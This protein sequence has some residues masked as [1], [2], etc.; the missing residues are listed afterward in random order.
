MVLKF[1]TDSSDRELGLH[2]ANMRPESLEETTIYILQHQFNHRTVYCI[3]ED[4]STE[5][6]V[7]SV[8]SRRD[9]TEE[10]SPPHREYRESDEPS[11]RSRA[12]GPHNLRETTGPDFDATNAAF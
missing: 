1:C 11:V 5:V 3:R 2:T 12:E 8:C 9:Y 10:R 6:A 4:R 7:R